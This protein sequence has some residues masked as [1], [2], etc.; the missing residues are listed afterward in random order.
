MQSLG[1]CFLVV[2]RLFWGPQD[3]FLLWDERIVEKVDEALGRFSISY[4]FKNVNDQFF[5]FW[6]GV[7]TGVYGPNLDLER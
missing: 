4:K 5:F 7:L 1:P 2:F 3:N 6:G